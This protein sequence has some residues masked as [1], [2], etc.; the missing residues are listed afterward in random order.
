MN[1]KVIGKSPDYLIVHG[2][3]VFK[4]FDTS[5]L[6][7]DIVF[8]ELKDRGYMPDWRSFYSAAEN[9]GWKP[10]TI[11]SRLRESLPIYNHTPD[12][13]EVVIS[14]LCENK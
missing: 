13:T 7:L 3:E 5:G 9:H 8:M 6:P 10:K 12:F 1:L 2:E 11:I 14:R 4:L